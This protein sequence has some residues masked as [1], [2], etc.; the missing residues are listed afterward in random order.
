MLTL[1]GKKTFGLDMAK[2]GIVDMKE[3]GIRESFKSKL[4]VGGR[5]PWGWLIWRTA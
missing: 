1:S 3:I 2:G 4:Q 5:Q